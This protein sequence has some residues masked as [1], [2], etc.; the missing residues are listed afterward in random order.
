MRGFQRGVC[1][2]GL[3]VAEVATVPC[4]PQLVAAFPQVTVGKGVRVIMPRDAA[5]A[6]TLWEAIRRM[7]C[8]S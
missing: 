4:K 1:D 2:G 5:W 7:L 8:D 3:V 6:G